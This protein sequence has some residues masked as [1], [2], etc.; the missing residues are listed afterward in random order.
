MHAA[1]RCRQRSMRVLKMV[2]AFKVIFTGFIFITWRAIFRELLPPKEGNVAIE[3][4]VLANLTL[5]ANLGFFSPMFLSSD[6][7]C[8]FLI[9]CLTE[10]LEEWGGMLG[11]YRIMTIPTRTSM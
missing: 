8:P 4:L 11:A 2:L 7:F 3:V 6:F 5:Q 9:N 1:I 10:H